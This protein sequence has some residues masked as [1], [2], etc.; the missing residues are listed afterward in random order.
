M[1]MMMSN[2]G[3][4]TNAGCNCLNRMKNA[5]INNLEYQVIRRKLKVLVAMM[6]PIICLGVG[7]VMCCDGE[8]RRMVI[9]FDSEDSEGFNN[10]QSE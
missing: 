4:T 6:T 9:G 5:T 10:Q 8:S 2:E 7:I 3:W 1:A